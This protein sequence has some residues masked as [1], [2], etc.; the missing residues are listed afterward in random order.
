MFSRLSQKILLRIFI[1]KLSYHISL[2]IFVAYLQP[3]SDPHAPP[4]YRNT[5]LRRIKTIEH[6]WP[7]PSDRARQ[8]Y[9]LVY[10]SFH[11]LWLICTQF[12]IPETDEYIHVQYMNITCSR[13]VHSGFICIHISFPCINNWRLGSG[14]IYWVSQEVYFVHENVLV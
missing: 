11:P 12:V 8:S 1:V 7:G 13:H 10:N 3:S 14:I 4:F 9:L 6:G 2:S 5:V